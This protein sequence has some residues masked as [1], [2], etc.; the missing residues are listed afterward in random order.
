M[1]GHLLDVHTLLANCLWRAVCV[2]SLHGLHIIFMWKFWHV[3]NFVS[4][5]RYFLK[6]QVLHCYNG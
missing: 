5:F 6:E 1:N 2:C 3:A 4:L